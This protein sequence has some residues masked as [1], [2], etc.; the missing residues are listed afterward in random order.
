MATTDLTGG[1]A[2]VVPFNGNKF[3]SV[4]NRITIPVTGLAAGDIFEAIPVKAGWLVLGT[5]W[6]PVTAVTDCTTM[7]ILVGVTG[8]TVNGFDADIDGKVTTVVKSALA[9]TYTAAG[10]LYVT[11]D[12][13]IDVEVHAYT[14]NGTAISGVYDL[15]AYGIDTN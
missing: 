2:A 9:E 6:K 1:A 11:A 14:A 4:K 8:G 3:F 5:I 13:T 12:D 15:I 7:T 10:G